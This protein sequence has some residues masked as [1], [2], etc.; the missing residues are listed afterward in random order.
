[1]EMNSR[2]HIT[3]SQYEAMKTITEASGD[4]LDKWLHTCVTF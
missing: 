2:V 1:M 4:T 3:E